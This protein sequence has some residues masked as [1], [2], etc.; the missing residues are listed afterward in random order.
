[1]ED[2]ESQ[3]WALPRMPIDIKVFSRLDIE[4]YIPGPSEICISIRDPHAPAPTLSKNFSDVLALE[5]DDCTERYSS[6][7]VPITPEQA[8]KIYNFVLSHEEN[9]RTLTI[10]CNAGL[11]RSPA[12]AL[13][14]A[15]QFR[16]GLLSSL[17]QEYPRYNKFVYKV[18]A[19]TFKSLLKERYPE[20]DSSQT[21]EERSKWSRIIKFW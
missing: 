14:L 19:E 5:F 18:V 7:E 16:P 6:L 2:K 13:A 12:L 17:E 10:H 20:A 8:R 4:R 3:K 11:S 15:K 9:I 1:M 21:N